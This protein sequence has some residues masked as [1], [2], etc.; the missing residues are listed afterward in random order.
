[1]PIAPARRRPL[2]LVGT[3]VERAVKVQSGTPNRTRVTEH[4]TEVGEAFA[5]AV[6]QRLPGE[7]TIV[8][9]HGKRWRYVEDASHMAG[10]WKVL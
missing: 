5:Y 9:G 10:D 4:F 3:P 6:R 2:S 1:M 8:E 7:H